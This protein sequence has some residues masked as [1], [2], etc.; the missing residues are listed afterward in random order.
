MNIFTPMIEVVEWNGSRYVSSLDLYKGV[1]YNHTQY[2]RWVKTQL[3]L[4]ATKDVDYFDIVEKEHQEKFFPKTWNHRHKSLWLKPGLY[5]L[6]IDMA[7]HVCLMAKSGKGK[8]I[9]E[10]LKDYENNKYRKVEL[11]ER[12]N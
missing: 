6:T 1:G 7:I 8:K 10:Y 3:H 4:I 5:F 2:A 9:K 11:L 12:H